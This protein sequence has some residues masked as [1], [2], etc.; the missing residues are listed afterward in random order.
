MEVIWESEFAHSGKSI[1]GVSSGAVDGFGTRRFGTGT[2][3]K[4]YNAQSDYC[5]VGS[6][7]RLYWRFPNRQR[8]SLANRVGLTF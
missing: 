2:S 4:P 1:A 8:P 5:I 3:H 7:S 6:S